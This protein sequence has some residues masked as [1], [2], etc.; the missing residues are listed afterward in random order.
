MARS[1]RPGLARRRILALQQPIR[2]LN[3]IDPGQV[4]RPVI[5]SVFEVFSRGF[6]TDQAAP[7]RELRKWLNF[8]RL[9]VCFL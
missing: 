2:T 1:N 7:A 3:N 9:P 8:S 6:V 5:G 4:G